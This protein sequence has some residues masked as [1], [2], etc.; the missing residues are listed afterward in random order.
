ME[1]TKEIVHGPI[2]Y[3]TFLY[4]GPDAVKGVPK[5]FSDPICN[6]MVQVSA[7]DIRDVK[8]KKMRLKFTTAK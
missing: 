3:S 1:I 5:M 7:S 2:N 8:R 6:P 4:G